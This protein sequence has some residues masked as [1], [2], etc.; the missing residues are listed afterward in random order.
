MLGVEKKYTSYEKGT[1]KNWER[2]KIQ[3]TKEKG[4]VIDI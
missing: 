4:E 1:E 3:R 2:E